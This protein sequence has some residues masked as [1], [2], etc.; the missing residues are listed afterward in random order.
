[1][2]PPGKERLASEE[3]QQ[4]QLLRCAY[5]KTIRLPLMVGVEIV[6]AG[7][8]ESKLVVGG[9]LHSSVGNW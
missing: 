5:H 1:M 6:A 4:Q 8:E 2:I 7:C 3:Q 9:K